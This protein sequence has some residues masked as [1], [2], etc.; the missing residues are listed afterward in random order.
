MS[1]SRSAVRVE[2]EK[3]YDAATTRRRNQMNQ[4]LLSIFSPMEVRRLHTFW[5]L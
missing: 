2:S 3:P 5:S 4:Y 1:I